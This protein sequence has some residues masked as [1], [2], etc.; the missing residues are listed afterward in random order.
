[1]KFSETFISD[2]LQNSQQISR[3][4][5]LKSSRDVFLI[6]VLYFRNQSQKSQIGHKMNAQ[7]K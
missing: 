3:K 4:L 1:M 2:V 6:T 7:V 5:S